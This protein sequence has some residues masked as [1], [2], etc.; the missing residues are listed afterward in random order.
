MH[1][2]QSLPAE[3]VQVNVVLGWLEELS[4]AYRA[5]DRLSDA[6]KCVT[7]ALWHFSNDKGEVHAQASQ[8]GDERVE[9]LLGLGDLRGAQDA[10]A[11]CLSARQQVSCGRE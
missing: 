9:L 7:K 6:L 3:S 2:V 8:L 11:A 10:A 4:L 1:I 5:R